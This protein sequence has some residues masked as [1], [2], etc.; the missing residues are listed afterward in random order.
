MNYKVFKV[1]L[2]TCKELGIIPTWENTKN[3]NAIVKGRS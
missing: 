2:K 3:F 1:W